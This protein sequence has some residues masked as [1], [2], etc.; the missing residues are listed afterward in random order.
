[1]YNAGV[2]AEPT[3]IEQQP[4]SFIFRACSGAAIANVWSLPASGQWDEPAGAIKWFR[5]PAQA[6]WLLVPGGALSPL[7][8]IEVPN[9]KIKLVT[10]TIGGNDA[11]FAPIAAACTSFV[12]AT[13]Q[14]CQDA[15]NTQGAAG[16]AALSA[17]LP[18]LLAHIHAS[19][20]KARIRQ[21][22]YP[23]LV[24]TAVVPNIAIGPGLFIDNTQRVNNMTAADLVEAFTRRV[25]RAIEAAVKTARG[26]GVPVKIVPQTEAAFTAHRLGDMEPWVNPI[27]APPDYRGSLH[28]NL[29]GHKA[30]ARRV[31]KALKI[32][33]GKWPALC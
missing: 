17:S 1:M 28:P 24:D 13:V 16:I 21:P 30:L 22:F 12:R 27:L 6:M 9:E 3:V 25:N 7:L 8:P 33:I 32:P 19:A 26:N 10:L 18:G 5:T 11:N 2:L 4:A 15:I 20:P 29:C 14:P 31:M 23:Q